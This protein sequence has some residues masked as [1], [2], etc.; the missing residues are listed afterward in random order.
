MVNTLTLETGR[1]P[2]RNTNNIPML[3]PEEVVQILTKAECNRDACLVSLLYLTGRRVQEILS[4]Q[5]KDFSLSNPNRVVFRTFN[6]K[7]FR[8]TKQGRFSIMKNGEFTK[9]AKNGL[10][11]KYTQRFYEM[12]EPEY[13]PIGVSGKLLNHYVIDYLATL[14]DEDYLFA[15][16]K[17]YGRAY[18]NQSRAYQIVRKM[19]DRLWLHSFRHINFSRLAKIYKNNPIDMHFITFHHRFDST[20]EYIHNVEKTN[21]LKK[22]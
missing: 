6:E 3:E 9:K 11:V 5:K 21:K 19:D 2:R 16:F 17:D 10:V 4:L 20:M 13:S 14:K 22:M 18:I 8:L 1:K 7:C 15:P 12:I